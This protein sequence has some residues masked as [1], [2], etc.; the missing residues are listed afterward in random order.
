MNFNSNQ[1]IS[2]DIIS[3]YI[4]GEILLEDAT[5][6]LRI[7]ERQFRRKVRAFRENGVLSVLHGNTG[8]K[9]PNKVSDQLTRQICT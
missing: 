1:Q 2:I 5:A 6:V 4:E 9:P 7:K 3:K 8:R